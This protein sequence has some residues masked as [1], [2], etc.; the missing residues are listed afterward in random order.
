M[1]RLA[2]LLLFFFPAAL[3]AQ[4]DDTSEAGRD[5]NLSP[6]FWVR[7]A[8]P[9]ADTLPLKST[10]VEATLAG[11]IA[12]VSVTQVYTNTGTTPIEA[13]YVFPG[14]TR[15]AVH[16]LT[17][18][19]GE[20]RIEARV[21][22]RQ[23]AR[24]T[25]E[26][27][28][29]A[30]KTTSLLEQQRPNVFQMNVANILPGDEVRVELRY[31]ELLV[32]TDG[33]YEFVYPGVVGPRYSK[34]A[35]AN[36]SADDT[37]VQNPYL[38][39]QTNDPAAFTLTVNC[40]TGVPMREAACYTH[41][42]SIV[43][44]DPSRARITLDPSETTGANRDFI[45]RYRLTGEALQAGLLVSEGSDE[46]FFL[47]MIQPPARPVAAT[48][49][50]RD[51]LFVV[52]VSG[53]MHGFPLATT[54]TLL[55][56]LFP[57]LRPQDTFNILLFAGDSRTL[58][59]HSL[60]ATPAN[61]EAALNLLSGQDGAGGTEL[62]PAL[63]AA[64]ALPRNDKL[65]RIITIITDGYVDVEA[66]AFEIVRTHAD[67]GNVFA[68]GIGSSVNRHLIEGLARAGQGE[69]FIVTDPDEAE[70]VARAFHDYIAAPVLTAAKLGFTGI[71]AYD[72][73]P[74]SLPDVFAQRPV[75]VFGKWRSPR[76][77]QL[78]LSGLTGAAPFATTL[79]LAS[80][81]TVSGKGLSHLWARHRIRQLMDDIA[82]ESTPERIAEVTTLGL[83]YNL[84]TRYTSF[85]AVDEVVRR[86]GGDLTTVKQPVPLPHGVA[87]GA[88]GGGG[89][90][91]T[92]PE[93]G[94]LALMLVGALVI[95][96]PVYRRHRGKRPLV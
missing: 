49:P 50:P 52:D 18:T 47:A 79:D 6:Y 62:L 55:R 44:A 56:Q 7:N 48:L 76:S 90:I 10:H 46:N 3:F 41:R 68:F 94:T 38:P 5:K 35:A 72:I 1:K 45:L 82:R 89:N 11:V 2:L 17:L 30:G 87:P 22:E 93:P 29:S 36:A 66:K 69:P 77:G 85:V 25:Y 40:L 64:F 80:A 27:A 42:T 9:G 32:P 13:V 91:P 74:R 60:P 53:S 4:S 26:A 24:R 34:T 31:T 73:E 15:A 39:T 33:I 67:K 75:I 59:P 16:G 14:S 12:D 58:S 81:Q 8:S 70:S 51:Y 71:D 61:L 43:Y 57:G 63:Q 88:I 84:L 28:K 95:L 78:T 21:Q 86:T 54:R 92:S 19:L 96:I 83:G 65:S 37:W 23:Q 20:R